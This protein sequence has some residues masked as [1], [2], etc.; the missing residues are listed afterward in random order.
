VVRV[1]PQHRFPSI[2]PDF[3]I[4]NQRAE[5]SVSGPDAALAWSSD[6]LLADE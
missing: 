4:L 1:L 3:R 5:G 6:E 2:A